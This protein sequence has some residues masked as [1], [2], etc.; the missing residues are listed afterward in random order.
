MTIE[1]PITTLAI[2]KL[3]LSRLLARSICASNPC[4]WSCLICSVALPLL[5]AST[6]R[7]RMSGSK[8]AA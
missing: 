5:S 2:I 4:N 7:F 1:E 3:K 6:V 8:A